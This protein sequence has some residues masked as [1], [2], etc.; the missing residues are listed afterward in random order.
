MENGALE[1]YLDDIESVG[2]ETENKTTYID[3]GAYAYKNRIKIDGKNRVSTSSL[4]PNRKAMLQNLF[5][6]ISS[7]LRTGKKKIITIWTTVLRVMKPIFYWLDN[8]ASSNSLSSSED[9]KARYEEYTYFLINSKPNL[10]A[11]SR[12]RLQEASR[13]FFRLASSEPRLSIGQGV[14]RLKGGQ[15][16]TLP[17]EEKIVTENLAMAYQLFTQLSGFVLDVLP[18]PF[19]LK[20]P[21]EAVNIIP[22]N[23]WV[24][25]KHRLAKRGISEQGNWVWDY[26]SGEINKVELVQEKYGYDSYTASR[27]ILAAKNQ[28]DSANINPRSAH[29]LR[30]ASLARTGFQVLML[31]AT[32]ANISEFIKFPWNSDIISVPGERQGFRAYKARARK[33]VYFELQSSFVPLLNRYL[34]LRSFL[35]EGRHCSTLFFR[36]GKEQFRKIDPQFLVTYYRQIKKMLSPAM[37]PITATEFRK[38]KSNWIIDR[39]GVITA[40]EVMQNT[41]KVVELHYSGSNK[42]KHQ[43]EFT[44]FYSYMTRLSADSAGLISSTSS[45]ACLNL[46][47]PEDDGS[48]LGVDKNC[49]DFYGCAFCKYYG[50][51]ADEEDL[52]KLHSMVAALELVQENSADFS[53]ALNQTLTRTRGNISSILKSSPDLNDTNERIASDIKNGN[54]DPFWQ[55]QVNLWIITGKIR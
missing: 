4:D 36:E 10:S 47:Y 19:S 11:R 51:H 46:G 33:E 8:L 27:E 23:I 55:A 16:P 37:Q 41:P 35:L 15:N 32:G 28:L 54:L 26:E 45:G 3:F 50:L 39:K 43:A 2:I 25:P 9:I 31:S 42:K 21:D 17:P 38:Y 22:C 18:Y 5:D 30:L 40:S 52:R 48:G 13:Y 12:A 44:K 49:D 53:D 7:D 1:L 20:L 6:D 24:M 14:P 34:K 29:R